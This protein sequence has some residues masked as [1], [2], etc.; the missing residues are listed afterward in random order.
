MD[1]M[2]ALKECMAEEE[3]YVVKA[4]LGHFIFRYIY[5]YFDGNGRTARFLMNFLFVVGGCNWVIVT[6]EARG[7]YLNS[8]EPAS[9]GKDIR[10]FA[11][12]IISMM[13][14]K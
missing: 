14:S 5:P 2:D 11:E 10:P 7:K 9:V 4:V 6:K 13:E 3:S 1:C 8:L 12:C